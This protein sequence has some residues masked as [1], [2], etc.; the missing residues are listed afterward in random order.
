MTTTQFYSKKT[1][2]DKPSV[3]SSSKPKYSKEFKEKVISEYLDSKLT[4]REIGEKY[5]LDFRLVYQWVKPQK[6]PV[7][8][9]PKF[10]DRW[11]KK[12][13]GILKRMIKEGKNSEEIATELGRT[14]AG[15]FARKRKLGIKWKMT[16]AFGSEMPYVS[17]KN[18]KS[19]EEHAPLEIAPVV[20]LPE[21]IQ[22]EVF[23]EKNN[24]GSEN[25]LGKEIDKLIEISKNLGISFTITISSEKNQ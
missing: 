8:E 14:R 11:N 12:D 1:R 19:L 18:N 5:G 21:N 22:E 24:L 17:R 10:H 3:K 2:Q 4:Y 7:T 15:I 9:P 13:D 6:T 25:N 23:M 20:S 16:K